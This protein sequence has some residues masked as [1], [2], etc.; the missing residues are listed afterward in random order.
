MQATKLRESNLRV[1]APRVAVLKA[2]AQRQHMDVEEIKG[3]V[4]KVLGKVSTQTVYTA[5]HTLSLHHLIRRFEP[6]GQNRAIYELDTGD[7]HHHVV[8]RQCSSFEDVPCQVETVPCMHPTIDHGYL[9]E[10]AEV[11]Y[12]GLCPQCQNEIGQLD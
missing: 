1:T 2:L 11:L 4:T 9:I 6:A 3:L 7:N 5:L 8:C 10:R 12:W